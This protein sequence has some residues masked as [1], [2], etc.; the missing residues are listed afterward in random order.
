MPRP[1][2]EFDTLYP[3]V[4][5]DPEDVMDPDSMYTVSEIA[6]LLQGLP[7]DADLDAETEDR[8]V[9]WCVPWLMAHTDELLI[10]DPTGDEPGYFGLRTEDDADEIPPD[11]D[12]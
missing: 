9:A 2:E 7:P 3:Y 10:N 1:K 12:V 4:L 11:A 5:Y 6:R 8:V